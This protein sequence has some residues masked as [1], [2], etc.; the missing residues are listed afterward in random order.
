MN[1][2]RHDMQL[3]QIKYEISS[4]HLAFV[5]FG[6]D[7]RIFFEH[8]ETTSSSFLMLE[9]QMTPSGAHPEAAG[10]LTSKML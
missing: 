8:V 1:N 4:W 10:I 3:T 7:S 5:D 6:A 9:R 2:F